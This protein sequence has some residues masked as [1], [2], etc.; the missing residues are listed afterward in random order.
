MYKTKPNANRASNG[1]VWVCQN[2]GVIF[3]FAAGVCFSLDVFIVAKGIAIL[4][5]VALNS[6]C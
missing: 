2:R 5:E 4:L 3:F 1:V 6:Y